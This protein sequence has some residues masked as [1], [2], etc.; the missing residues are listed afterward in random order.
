METEKQELTQETNLWS[1]VQVY[2]L[3]VICLLLGIAAGYLLH[4]TSPST[5][6][7]PTMAGSQQQQPNVPRVQ[8]VTPEQLEHMA[9]KQAEPLLAK[10]KSN[11][12]DAGALAETGKTFF[13]AH[14]FEKSAEYF[15]RSAKI[16]PDAD[17]LTTL[18]TAYHHAG[19]EDKA[20]DALQRALEVD[21][22]FANALFNLGMLRWQAQSD[23]KG[24]IEAWQTLLKTNPNHPKRE[25]V[26]RMIARVKQHMNLSPAKNVQKPIM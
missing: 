1:N 5:P 12:K 26:E 17:V 4:S 10:I 7:V 15:E 9:E 18:A 19:Q 8:D 11:P 20:I 25:T 21:P 16:H 22:K 23:P 13:S 14:Q 6:T 3:G 24:A 2:A